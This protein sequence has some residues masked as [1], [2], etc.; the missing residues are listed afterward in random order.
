MPALPPLVETRT[1]SCRQPALLCYDAAADTA[2]DAVA[3]GLAVPLA[4]EL[5]TVAADCAASRD[6]PG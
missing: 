6:M 1:T 3:A 5:G 4:A 2:T